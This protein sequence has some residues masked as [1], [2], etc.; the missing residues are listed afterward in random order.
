[1]NVEQP[2]EFAVYAVRYASRR[3]F[4][5]QHFLDFDGTSG[6]PHPTAYYVWLALSPRRA[7]VI[8]AG[9]DPARASASRGID[10]VWS[11]TEG[12]EALGVA[13][14]DVEHLVLTHLHYDHTGSVARFPSARYAVQRAEVDYWTGPWARRIAREHWLTSNDDLGHLLGRAGAARL[15]LVD[16][17]REVVPGLSV[18]LV[19]G[20][21]AG[22]QVVRVRTRRGHVVIAS[23]ASH[24]YENIE[25]DRP[26]PLLHSMP[27]VYAAFDRVNELADGPELVVAGHDPDVIE[28]YPPASATFAGRIARIA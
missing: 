14:A 28:R 17:D 11:P 16:G 27:G 2:E 20:H 18:H 23:D 8:D 10:F 19:G 5:G 13:P 26:A 12:L 25:Q 24:F 1:M 9:I 7:V 3:A 21:T 6:E 4:R 15:D 22:M